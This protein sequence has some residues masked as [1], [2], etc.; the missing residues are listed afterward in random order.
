MKTDNIKTSD[1]LT[2]MDGEAKRVRGE[3]SRAL[4]S[5]RDLLGMG[6]AVAAPAWAQLP[7]A[8]AITL[9]VPFGAG[10]SIDA[11]GRGFADAMAQELKQAVVVDNRAGASGAIGAAAAARASP[12]GQTLFLGASSTQAVLPNLSTKLQYDPIR[13]FTPISLVAEVE[14]ALVVHPSLPVSTMSELAAYCKAQGG[15]TAFGSSGA[16]GITHLAGEL[17]KTS[18]GF[19]AVHVPYKASSAVDMAL[20]GGEVQFAFATLASAMPHIQAGKMR[21]I[22]LASTSR[23]PFLP[24]VPTTAE[25]GYPQVIAVSWAGL[26]GPAGMEKT[27]VARLNKASVAALRRPE[28]IQRFQGVVARAVPS[29]PDGLASYQAQDHVRWGKVVAKAGIKLES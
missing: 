9:L 15:K 17:F 12:N 11:I 3:R 4:L 21:A 19:D 27:L 13:D 29:T 20:L 5:R 23:S 1:L 10:G 22:A 2:G 28:L 25:A 6:L 16:G 26:Y 7:S 24:Q 8:H 18:A 14:N